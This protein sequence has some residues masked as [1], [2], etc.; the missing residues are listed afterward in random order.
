MSYQLAEF[1]F[2]PFNSENWKRIGIALLIT[3]VITYILIKFESMFNI[4]MGGSGGYLANML[5]LGI[6]VAGNVV[7]IMSYDKLRG[8]K[9][10][11]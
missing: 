2:S 11:D 4:S 6:I 7:F 5:L 3:T 1:S 8:C 9:F 10:N